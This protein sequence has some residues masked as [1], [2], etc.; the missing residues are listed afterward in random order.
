M[1]RERE[2]DERFFQ[3][4]RFSEWRE[5]VGDD[6]MGGYAQ[7][8]MVKGTHVNEFPGGPAPDE[9]R[10]PDAPEEGPLRQVR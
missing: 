10:A 6:L 9:G 3:P 2:L 8:V 1:A 5:L 7:V 4:K